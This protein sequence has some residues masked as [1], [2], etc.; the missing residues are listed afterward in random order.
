MEP[1]RD[2]T[3]KTPYVKKTKF[4]NFRKSWHCRLRHMKSKGLRESHASSQHSEAID[5]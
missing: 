4:D 5:V 3:F 2:R 1:I